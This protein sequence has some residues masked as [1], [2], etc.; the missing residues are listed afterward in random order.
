[1][2]VCACAHD[3]DE[4]VTDEGVVDCM[5]SVD[6]TATSNQTQVGNVTDAL[7]CTVMYGI[8]GHKARHAVS[9]A[10]QGN[11]TGIVLDAES[12]YVQIG[13]NTFRLRAG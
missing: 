11:S 5:H 1:M 8:S 10:C 4:H 9:A 7:E 13:P 6:G 2:H 3:V 12:V